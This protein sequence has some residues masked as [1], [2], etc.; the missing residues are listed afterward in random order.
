ML[1]VASSH[2]SFPQ[3]VQTVKVSVDEPAAAAVVA[4]VEVGKRAAVPSAA[5]AALPA[6]LSAAAA[7]AG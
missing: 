4:D 5:A 6:A 1:A 7:V 3:A 2:A